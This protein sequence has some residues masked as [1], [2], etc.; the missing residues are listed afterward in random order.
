MN[1][2][3]NPKMTLEKEIKQKKPFANI[4]EKTLVNLMYTHGWLVEQMRNHFDRFDITLKQYNI[5]RILRGAQG[6]L[7][8]STIR[9]RMIDKMSDTTRL[10]NRMIKKEWVDKRTCSVDRRLVDIYITDTGLNKLEEIENDPHKM[11]HIF[12]SMTT[13]ETNQLSGLLDKLRNYKDES[14]VL[15]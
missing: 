1:G 2:V 14:D 7:T 11:T 8:T 10:I 5:L 13:E 4:E 15:S 3:Q 6:P 12:D 9:E